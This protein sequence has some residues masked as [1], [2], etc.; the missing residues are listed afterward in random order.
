MKNIA[1][2][3][4]DKKVFY[5]VLANKL[6]MQRCFHYG[7]LIV[8]DL[9]LCDA[10]S[11]H[12]RDVIRIRIGDEIAVLNGAGKIGVGIIK[13]FDRKSVIVGINKVVLCG[14]RQLQISLVQA[15]LLNNNNDFIVREATAIGVSEI[16]FFEAENSECKLHDKITNKLNRW[17]AISVGACKQSGN[18]FLPK[19]SFCKNFFDFKTDEKFLKLFGGLSQKSKRLGDVLSENPNARHI[20]ITIGPEGDFSSREYEY[21]RDNGFLECRLTNNILRSESAALYALSIVDHF[22]N[23]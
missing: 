19:I 4:S 13:F 1:Y 22:Y 15:A 3:I 14:K 23:C 7:D 18:P 21:M 20:Y 17:E 8:G 2:S 6:L 10:E 11:H 12:L 9:T 16:I 5:S